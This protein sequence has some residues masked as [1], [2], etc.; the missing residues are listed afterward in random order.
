MRLQ[1]DHII[2][3]DESNLKQPLQNLDLKMEEEDGKKDDKE[4]ESDN[5]ADHYVVGDDK[6]E[7]EKN[8][9]EN[10]G[11]NVNR[12]EGKRPHYPMNGMLKKFN[13]FGLCKFWSCW[14]H[15]SGHSN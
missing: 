8:E 4:R 10:D 5:D 9:N 15:Y 1:S 11:E 12:H 2:K 6:D 13:H 3:H 7:E 14:H